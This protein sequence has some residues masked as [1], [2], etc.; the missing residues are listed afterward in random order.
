MSHLDL[1]PY[2]DLTA[3]DAK[4]ASNPSIAGP[5]GCGQ[6]SHHPWPHPRLNPSSSFRLDE[7]R[8]TFGP[9]SRRIPVSPTMWSFQV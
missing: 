7:P 1:V 9:T 3:L 6:T 4:L 2:G 5:S 8:A